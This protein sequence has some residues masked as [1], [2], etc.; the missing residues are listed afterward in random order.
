MDE[1]KDDEE[2]EASS[3]PGLASQPPSLQDGIGCHPK[4]TYISIHE[5]YDEFSGL[6]KFEDKPVAG[7]F[8]KVN[9]LYKTKW[10]QDLSRGQKEEWLRLT[11][12][13]HGIDA[14]I[15]ELDDRDRALNNLDLVFQDKH[16]VNHTTF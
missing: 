16:G 9:E 13:V 11:M 7:G 15:I 12:T 4:P 1:D 2:E 14:H 3:P 6:G 5:L 8:A 10:T